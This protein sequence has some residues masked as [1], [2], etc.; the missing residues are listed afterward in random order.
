LNLLVVIVADHGA[1]YPLNISYSSPDK[2]YIPLLYTGGV[3]KKDTVLHNVCSQT[4][5]VATILNQMN[6]DSR[7]FY[8]SNNSFRSDS[9]GYAFYSFNNGSGWIDSG[10]KRVISH[11]DN[12]IILNQG[13]CHY[14]EDYQRSYFQK[15]LDDFDTK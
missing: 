15:L 4:D 9:L 8:F 3:V 2:F 5:I 7:E 6:I 1:R 12:Q 10:G 14:S 11:D 13:Q